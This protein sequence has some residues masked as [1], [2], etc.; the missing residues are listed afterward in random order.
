M[1]IQVTLNSKKLKIAT[2]TLWANYSK[3]KEKK[4]GKICYFREP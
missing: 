4:K 2:P 1:N 3:G